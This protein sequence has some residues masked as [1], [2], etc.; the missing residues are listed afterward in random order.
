MTDVPSA[1]T[2]ST[3]QLLN[4]R[5]SMRTVHAPHWLVS[6]PILVPVSDS[7]FRSACTSSVRGSMS[8][9]LEV[10]FTVSVTLCR[11]VSWSDIR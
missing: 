6:Q 3:V 8:S 9:V 1:C 4:E 7:S 5:P 2:A 11:A 10:P